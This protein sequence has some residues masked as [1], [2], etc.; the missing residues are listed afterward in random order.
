VSHVSPAFHSDAATV[1]LHGDR[2]LLIVDADEV[3]LRFAAGFD[4]FLRGRGYVLELVSYRLHGNVRR[5]VD[6][7]VTP[8]DDVNDLLDLFRTDLDSLEAVEG[9]RVTLQSLSDSTDIVVLSN[10][11]AAQALPRL[12]NLARCKLAF[13]LQINAGVKGP[14][15]RALAA[16]A[17][18]PAFF[19]DDIPQHL[20]SAA[21]AAPHVYRI[22][23]TGDERLKPHMLQCQH[24][25][26]RAAHWRD[27]EHFIR[28]RL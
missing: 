17:G 5:A 27:I 1:P 28:E 11:P 23:M 26:L 19:V 7:S 9:A 24:A 12:R 25:H 2:P 22:Q 8:N 13:P 10:I 15:V 6:Q 21:E 16:R 18:A 20:E 14:A 4:A 3:L